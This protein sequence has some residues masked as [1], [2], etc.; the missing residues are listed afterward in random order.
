MD[1]PRGH[2]DGITCLNRRFDAINYNHA[3]TLRDEDN[4]FEFV[5]MKEKTSAGP[6][7]SLCK[8]DMVGAAVSAVKKHLESRFLGDFD[9]FNSLTRN[10]RHDRL[11]SA[12]AATAPVVGGGL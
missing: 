3:T 9:E 4:F 12:R 1:G 8:S 6:K 10:D 2:E 5:I 7:F 11:L